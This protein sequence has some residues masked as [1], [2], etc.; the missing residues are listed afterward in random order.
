M[1]DGEDAPLGHRRLFL[2]VMPTPKQRP[3]GRPREYSNGNL[4]MWPR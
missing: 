1:L 3:R 2:V 4:V